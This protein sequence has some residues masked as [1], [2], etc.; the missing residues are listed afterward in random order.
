MNES[1]VGH[2]ASSICQLVPCGC[3]ERISIEDDC[4]S[5]TCVGIID[6]LA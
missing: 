1:Q 5:Q 3:V 2:Y 6:A 4:C